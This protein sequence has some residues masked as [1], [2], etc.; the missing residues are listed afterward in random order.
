M[1]SIIGAVIIVLIIGVIWYVWHRVTSWRKRIRN[2]T[3]EAQ[4][5]LHNTFDVLHED[6][7]EQFDGLKKVRGKKRL[8]EEERVQEHIEKG[9]DIAE[10]FAQKEIEDIE[11]EVE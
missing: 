7:A 5:T 2:E 4:E 10:R 3:H 8:A 1:N 6:I 9:L 11:K